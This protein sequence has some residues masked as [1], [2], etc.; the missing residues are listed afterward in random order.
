MRT[1]RRMTANFHV[2]GDGDRLRAGG[3][4]GIVWSPLRNG[5]IGDIRFGVAIVDDQDTRL[6]AGGVMVN[7]PSPRS[8]TLDRS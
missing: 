5:P 7:S 4:L 2:G 6:R 3:D 8:L 1:S